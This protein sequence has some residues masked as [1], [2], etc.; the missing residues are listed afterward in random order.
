MLELSKIFLAGKNRNLE[1]I[2]GKRFRTVWLA[3]PSPPIREV[4]ISKT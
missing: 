1:E 3:I 4:D 2:P